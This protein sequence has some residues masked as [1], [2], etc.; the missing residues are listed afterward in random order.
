MA[1]VEHTLL[2]L[3]TAKVDSAFGTGF[4]TAKSALADMQRQIRDNK[5]TIGKIDEY[6]KAVAALNKMESASKTSASRLETQRDKVARLG[7]ELKELNVDLG[8]M[9]RK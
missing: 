1:S 5:N 6:E 3:L 2:F 9:S 8:L 7:D 4:S